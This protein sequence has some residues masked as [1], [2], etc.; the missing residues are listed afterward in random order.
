[1]AIALVFVVLIALGLYQG[2]KT[3]RYTVSNKKI[4]APVRFVLISDLHSQYW[5]KAQEKIIRRVKKA[6][7][8]GILLAG[9]MDDPNGDPMAAHTLVKALAPLAPCY[10]A[11]GS[12]DMLT[13]DMEGVLSRMRDAGAIPLASESVTAKMKTNRFA[14]SGID[15]PFSAYI[16]EEAE[17]GREQRACYIKTLDAFPP[18]DPDVFNLLIAHRPEFINEYAAMGFDMVVCGHAHGGQVRVPFLLNGL[19]APGQG[20]FPKFAGGLYTRRGFAEIVSRGLHFSYFRPRFFCRPEVVIIN[21]V[22]GV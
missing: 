12:H 2:L 4:T 5:G 8:N 3:V 16:R 9:D 14:I 1:M 6:A 19:Y 13:W 21:L 22:N 20:L 17:T 7:P 10:Y 18:L 15:E 11:T